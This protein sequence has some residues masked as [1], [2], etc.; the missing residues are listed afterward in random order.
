MWGE[1]LQAL[2][3]SASKIPPDEL[4]LA[5]TLRGNDRSTSGLSTSDVS[6]ITREVG[7]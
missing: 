1:K 3:I 7:P 4:K 5:K 6:P 2:V